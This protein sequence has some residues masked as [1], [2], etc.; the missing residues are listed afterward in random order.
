MNL[1]EAWSVYYIYRVGKVSFSASIIL[2][3]KWDIKQPLTELI[4]GLLE[5]VHIKQDLVSLVSFFFF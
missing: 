2:T 1:D 3:G 4:K 5:R